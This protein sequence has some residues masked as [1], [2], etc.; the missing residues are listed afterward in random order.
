MIRYVAVSEP[1]AS[2]PSLEVVCACGLG[3]LLQDKTI[4][5]SWPRFLKLRSNEVSGFCPGQNLSLTVSAPLPYPEDTEIFH[6]QATG[7][8]IRF[9]PPEPNRPQAGVAEG[10]GSIIYSLGIYGLS[11]LPLL[12]R[13][14]SARQRVES[15]GVKDNRQVPPQAEA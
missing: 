2:L 5:R 10:A 3:F 4:G 11:S 14:G 13:P 9:D 6:L 7:E 1:Q 15:I 12:R 8:V